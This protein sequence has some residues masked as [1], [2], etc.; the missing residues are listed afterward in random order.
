MSRRCN[1]YRQQICER[2][3]A[4]QRIINQAFVLVLDKWQQRYEDGLLDTVEPDL[5]HRDELPTAEIVDSLFTEIQAKFTN[6][7]AENPEYWAKQGL[8]NPPDFDKFSGKAKLAM[9]QDLQRTK[10]TAKTLISQFPQLFQHK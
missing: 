2:A 9:F 1:L 10:R 5:S 4:P 7:L 6:E 8:H 3:Y